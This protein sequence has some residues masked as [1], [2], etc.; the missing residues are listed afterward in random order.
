[1]SFCSSS[2][3]KAEVELLSVLR[4]PAE[5]G[6]FIAKV[7]DEQADFGVVGKDLYD[8][9]FGVD[10]AKSKIKKH[11]KIQNKCEQTCVIV[12]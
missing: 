2:A 10:S 9:D 12:Q 1:M 4:L 6:G 11:F 3:S 5:S 7:E 8:G